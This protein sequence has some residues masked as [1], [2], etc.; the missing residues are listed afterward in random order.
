MPTTPATQQGHLPE[1]SGAGLAEAM[2]RLV[3]KD[4]QRNKMP[5]FRKDQHSEHCPE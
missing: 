5:N 1:A 2:M 3:I 4:K